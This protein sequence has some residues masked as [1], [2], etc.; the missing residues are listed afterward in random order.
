M[1]PT[2]DDVVPAQLNLNAKQFA[3]IPR[4][5]WAEALGVM[6]VNGLQQQPQLLFEIVSQGEATFVRKA[7]AVDEVGFARADYKRVFRMLKGA[8]TLLMAALAEQHAKR[9]GL[10]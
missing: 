6:M 2:R 9:H 3:S 5:R 7:Y 10:M 1:T 8:S 4:Q